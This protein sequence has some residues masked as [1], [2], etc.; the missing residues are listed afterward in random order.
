LTAIVKKLPGAL[1]K[2]V[3]ASLIGSLL[4][5][6][7]ADAET[8]VENATVELAVLGLPAAP[9]VRTIERLLTILRR[10]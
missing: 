8:L 10:V 1:Y 4:A 5:T 6:D 7:R 9:T 3:L 2:E